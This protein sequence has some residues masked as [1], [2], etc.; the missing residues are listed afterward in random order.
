MS[1]QNKIIYLL[2]KYLGASFRLFWYK[3]SN[4]IYLWGLSNWF[5]DLDGRK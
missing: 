1:L 4:H 2:G 5:K 3:K